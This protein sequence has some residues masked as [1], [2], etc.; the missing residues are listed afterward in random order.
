[1]A[2]PF[3]RREVFVNRESEA[4]RLAG[5]VAAHEVRRWA[6]EQLMDFRRPAENLTSLYGPGGIGKST[7]ARHWT[8][9]VLDGRGAQGGCAF[10]DFAHPASAGF[11]AVLLRL[12][13]ALAPLAGSWPMFDVALAVYWA[14][15]HPG[16]S[17]VTFVGRSSP[18]VARQIG[19]IVD[20]VL[21]GFGAISFVVNA[22]NKARRTVVGNTRLER[23]RREFPAL[24][25]LLD[26]QD[27]DEMLANMPIL[28]AAD[29]ERARARGPVLALC[30]LD[31][32]EQVQAMPA[33]RDGMED[34]VARL[35]YLMPNVLFLA[36]GRR[37]LAW[38]EPTR[39]A[40]LRYGGAAL[41][42][43]L[44][45]PIEVKALRDDASREFL[46]T[47]LTVGGR[48]VVD[49]R[50]RE[51]IVRGAAGSP[52]Y[53]ELS[54]GLYQGFLARGESPPAEAFGLPFPEL[55]LRVMRDMTTAERALL[56][57]AALLEAFDADLLAAVLPE[58]GARRIAA[59]LDR[60]EIGHDPSVWPPF[61]LPDTLRSGVADADE[62]TDD[63]W[64]EAERRAHA[65]RAIA[66]LAE[67]ALAVWEDGRPHLSRRCASATLLALHAAH[68][69][70]L[71]PRELGDMLYTLGMLGHRQ[72]VGG[73]QDFPDSPE[74]LRLVTFARLNARGGLG[75]RDC[76]L[77][78]RRVAG[79]FAG[80][81]YA[82]YFHA[83]LASRAHIAGLLDV[84]DRHNDAIVD[85]GGYVSACLPFARA[86]GALR[87]SD[88]R[89]VVRLMGD[90]APTA[91]DR[92]RRFDMLG[93]AALHNARFAEAA[94]LFRDALDLARRVHAPLWEARA[95]RHRVLALM[96]SDPEAA[97]P[98]IPR[99]R[100]LSAAVFEEIG[101]AQCD[102]AELV[103]RAAAGDGRGALE[104]I[105]A[106]RDRY[107]ELGA[108]LEL[109]PV[110]AVEVLFEAAFG[111]PGRASGR[112]SE[113]RGTTLPVW[114][115][116]AGQWAGADEPAPA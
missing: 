25:V 53:L 9:S 10:V 28:L 79:D 75:S 72:I 15:K 65:E 101:V 1:M 74:L 41:W 80:S 67:L 114:A 58:V 111:D 85:D 34:L 40:G 45:H 96:W 35:V 17:L 24:Q 81:P 76:Y 19:Q 103:V 38:H 95:L 14:R 57:A 26:E 106:V 100:E 5:W 73:L 97:R 52:L 102:L 63:G 94:G 56:R 69:H 30:V 64:T 110:E 8:A 78:L 91:I 18:E 109:L 51:R 16:E 47:R 39:S 11:E 49:A 22:L 27:P 115:A 77:A 36:S 12:R 31:S 88:Y 59:F 13:A 113:L 4:E 33:E 98:L 62:R 60:P 84:A 55:V 70:G 61:R 43:G 3:E 66:R 6:P 54:T 2:A 90:D 107:A 68:E 48:S 7:L 21:G 116:V 71:L 112:A 92:I 89:E 86:D 99:A 87:R 23:M 20:Q 104:G 37:R 82:N 108:T 46:A 93:H 83:E 105:A 29:L 42:P 50:A 32:L 44:A